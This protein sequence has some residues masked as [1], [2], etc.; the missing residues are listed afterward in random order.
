MLSTAELKKMLWILL[1]EDEK[2]R[3]A[4]TGLTDLE[5]LIKLNRG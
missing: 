2:F 1:K 3:Y 5:E 4:I